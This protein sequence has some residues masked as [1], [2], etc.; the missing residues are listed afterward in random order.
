MLAAFAVPFAA[1]FHPKT[2]L[3]KQ[4]KNVG[5]AMLITAI[6][7]IAWRGVMAE[8]GVW[9]FNTRYLVGSFIGTLPVEELLYFIAIPYACIFTYFALNQ[10]IEKDPLFPHQEVISSVM[11]V[12]LLIAGLYHKH[13]LY[14]GPL[15]LLLGGFLA[16]QMLKLRPRYMGKFYLAFLVLLIP[17]TILHGAFSGWFTD[18]PIVRFGEV[19]TIGAKLGSIPLEDILLSMFLMLMPIAIWEW[20]EDYFYYKKLQKK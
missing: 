13:R 10:F 6:F 16:F 20:L 18:E 19:H 4:W 5:V 8:M 11:I 9:N 7:F 12:V 17:L 14:A 2:P 15:F 1:S 3:Y